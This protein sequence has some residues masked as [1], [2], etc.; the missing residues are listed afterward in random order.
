M[1]RA[2]RALALLLAL[3]LALSCAACATLSPAQRTRSEAIALSARSTEIDCT[4]DDACARPSSD[5]SA[6]TSPA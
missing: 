1:S 2:A 5:R 6:P 4:R 3:L